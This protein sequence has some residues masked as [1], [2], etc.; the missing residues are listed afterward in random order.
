MSLDALVL[1]ALVDEVL[2]AVL[3]VELDDV[4]AVACGNAYFKLD[5]NC[6]ETTCKN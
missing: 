3:R 1:V 4:L 5:K 6:S 2:F